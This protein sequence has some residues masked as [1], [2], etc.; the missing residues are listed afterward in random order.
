MPIQSFVVNEGTS[1][2]ERYAVKIAI[3]AGIH[4]D[5][6]IKT[7]P[8]YHNARNA[9]VLAAMKE[10]LPPF[11][12]RSYLGIGFTSYPYNNYIQ[13]YST[14]KSFPLKKGDKVILHFEDKVKMELEFFYANKSVG[15]LSSN[16]CAIK[17]ADLALINQEKNTT[18]HGGF[19]Y[20]EGNKQYVSEKTGQNMFRKMAQHILTSKND[21]FTRQSTLPRYK[22]G[23]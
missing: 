17:D 12:K 8:F 2:F 14:Y 11:K 23:A 21:V 16:V 13:F 18:L 19:M 9:S 4:Q 1:E 7:F 15:F 5:E 22:A 20:H 6:F 3:H 10:E